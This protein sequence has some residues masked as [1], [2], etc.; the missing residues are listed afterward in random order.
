MAV[1]NAR[2]ETAS[3]KLAAA[4]VRKGKQASRDNLLRN[5]ASSSEHLATLEAKDK[6]FAE[7][8]PKVDLVC[9]PLVGTGVEDV[10]H[11]VFPESLGN[12]P[13]YPV[14]EV[15]NELEFDRLGLRP[16]ARR[17]EGIQRVTPRTGEPEMDPVRLVDIRLLHAS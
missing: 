1:A 5:V 15:G 7:A 11:G 16:D 6:E 17:Q 8:L 3:A 10:L 2:V 13:P 12:R 14:P 4:Q 9:Q